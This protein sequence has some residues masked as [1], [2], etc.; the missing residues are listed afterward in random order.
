MAT[1]TTHSVGLRSVWTHIALCV[2][3]ID[4]SI[5]WYERFTHLS[6]RSAART[7][8]KNAWLGDDPGRLA[9]MLVLGHPTKATTCRAR[10]ASAA[11]PFAHIG[12]ELLTKEAV[13]GLPHAPRRKVAW[14][15]GRSSCPSRLATSASSRIQTATPS[16]SHSTRASTK[17]RVRFG[18]GPKRP[19]RLLARTAPCLGG[20][21]KVTK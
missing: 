2:K 11:R 17:R 12:I 19:P 4:A 6:L 7:H 14:G 18:D 20:G 21:V 16:S 13:D 1:Q 3:D 5:A 8:G 9:F 15:S 10:G